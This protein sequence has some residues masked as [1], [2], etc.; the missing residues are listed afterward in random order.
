MAS[1]AINA[2]L[3]LGL[4]L[5]TKHTAD[6]KGATDENSA[7]AQLAPAIQAELQGIAQA[8]SSGQISAAEAIQ[9]VQTSDQQTQAYLQKQQGKAGVA[10]NPDYNGPITEVTSNPQIN[11][12]QGVGCNKTC[13]VGCCIYFNSWKPAFTGMEALFQTGNPFTVT[14]GAMQSNKYGFP[15]FPSYVISVTNPP[16]ASING[17]ESALTDAANLLTGNSGSVSS[18]SIVGSKSINPLYIIGGI[19]LLAIGIFVA[20]EK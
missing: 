18:S 13:T 16:I 7:C 9:A 17:V 1:A 10:W 11:L 4:G 20:K 2:A 6:V 12:G 19:A 14:V 8:Y 3:Q 5:L 15:G